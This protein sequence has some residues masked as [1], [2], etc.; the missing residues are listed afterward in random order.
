MTIPPP[1]APQSV[2][3]PIKNFSLSS[4]RMTRVAVQAARVTAWRRALCV[5][6]VLDGTFLGFQAGECILD[7]LMYT[8][9]NGS[10]RTK[11]SFF[12]SPWPSAFS[13]VFCAA[14]CHRFANAFQESNSR[15]R[16]RHLRSGWSVHGTLTALQFVSAMVV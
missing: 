8:P 9:R 3:E 4:K 5:Q 14:S 7:N 13:L 16:H 15:T 11:R 1:P 10:T 2:E 12:G 6:E